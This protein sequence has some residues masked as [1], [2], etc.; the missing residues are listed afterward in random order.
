MVG[1][2]E[3]IGVGICV[4]GFVLIVVYFDEVVVVYNRKSI[5]FCYRDY[6][7]YLYGL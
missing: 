4:V 2:Y 3:I 1:V 7:Y 6:V 5:G